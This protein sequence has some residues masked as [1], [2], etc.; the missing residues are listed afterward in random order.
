MLIRQLQDWMVLLSKVVNLFLQTNQISKFIQISSLSMVDSSEQ[1]LNKNLTSTN[2]HLLCMEVIMEN[3]N[4]CSEI[5]VLDA[6]HASS[7]CMEPQE[8]KPGV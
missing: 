7:Q 6:W 5:K 8:I 1:E 2:L 4:R 3:S